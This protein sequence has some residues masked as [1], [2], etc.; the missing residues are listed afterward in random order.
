MFNSIGIW[1]IKTAN[2]WKINCFHWKSFIWIFGIISCIILKIR[3]MDRSMHAFCWTNAFVR[4]K[5]L[6]TILSIVTT[7][8]ANMTACT[9]IGSLF[10]LQFQASICTLSLGCGHFNSKRVRLAKQETLTSPGHLVSPVVCR[11]PWMSTVVLYCWCHSDSASVLL[12]FTLMHS[13][14]LLT[15]IYHI[16]S[17]ADRIY[18][19]GLK[20]VKFSSIYLKLNSLVTLCWIY[21]N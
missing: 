17:K 19:I 18:S 1:D 16:S 8:H 3:Y 13:R 11:D 6:F 15:L 20:I 21:V 10:F 14:L 5:L 4:Q 9:S 12:Y 7:L 2:V